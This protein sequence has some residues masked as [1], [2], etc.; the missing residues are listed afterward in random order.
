MRASFICML[1]VFLSCTAYA[2]ELKA[3]NGDLFSPVEIKALVKKKANTEG[4][5]ED[6]WQRLLSAK[7][8]LTSFFVKLQNSDPDVLS[9]LSANLRAKYPDNYAVFNAEFGV[10]TIVSYEIIDFVFSDNNERVEFRY[11]LTEMTEGTVCTHQRAIALAMD[12]DKWVI[13]SF[14]EFSK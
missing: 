2:T 11:F 10:D 8:S 14:G 12:R 1:A 4:L 3:K 9:L 5:A 13:S 6:D 7:N